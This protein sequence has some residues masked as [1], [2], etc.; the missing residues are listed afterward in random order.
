MEYFDKCFENPT[1]IKSIFYQNF[2]WIAS[3]AG[4]KNKDPYLFHIANI[5]L[6]CLNSVFYLIMTSVVLDRNRRIYDVINGKIERTSILA[7]SL[8][9]VHAIHTESVSD[10]HTGDVEFCIV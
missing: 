3:I 8:F 6:H 2:R 10:L 5:F 1:I 4:G 9:A 7:A